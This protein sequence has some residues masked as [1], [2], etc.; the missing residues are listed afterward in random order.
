MYLSK[1]VVRPFIMSAYTG[2]TENYQSGLAS[3]ENIIILREK[4]SH[5]PSTMYSQDKV[6]IV[7]AEQITNLRLWMEGVCTN[8]SS[9]I[10]GLK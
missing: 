10:H 2:L 5:N 9:T 6:Y 7:L 4:N 8:G 3:N 1:N